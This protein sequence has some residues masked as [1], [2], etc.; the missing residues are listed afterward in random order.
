[1][2]IP[3]LVVF[4]QP[5][6]TY[7]HPLLVH[8]NGCPYVLFNQPPGW[9][10]KPEKLAYTEWLNLK[11]DFIAYP[12]PLYSSKI[13]AFKF[14]LTDTATYLGVWE[15]ESRRMC[16]NERYCLVSERFLGYIFRKSNIL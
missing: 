3:R 6:S 10:T 7:I 13:L 4:H 16:R 5:P 12:V 1:M 9:Q 11:L 14:S 8:M 2:L 15:L